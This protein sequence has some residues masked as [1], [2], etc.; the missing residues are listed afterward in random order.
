[1]RFKS[2]IN[3]EPAFSDLLNYAHLVDDGVILNKDGAFL[4]SYQFKGIDSHS[5]SGRDLDTVAVS[6]NRM[7]L[8]NV[9]F[10]CLFDTHKSF[11]CLFEIRSTV[12]S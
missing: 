1:M 4:M 6:F 3:S 5:A 7:V 10:F 8:R 2:L 12:L 9:L 11:C